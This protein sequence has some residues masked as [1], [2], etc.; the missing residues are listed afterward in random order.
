[1]K[2]LKDKKTGGM[3]NKFLW[4]LGL[5]IIELSLFAIDYYSGECSSNCVTS[6]II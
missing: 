3:F 5:L 1:M 2:F 6:L 4:G